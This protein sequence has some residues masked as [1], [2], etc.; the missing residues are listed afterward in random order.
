MKFILLFIFVRALTRGLVRKVEVKGFDRSSEHHA[1]RRTIEGA[2]ERTV[3]RMDSASVEFS[4]SCE[5]SKV[6]GS[7]R[8]CTA[9]ARRSGRVHTPRS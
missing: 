5:A 9:R 2:P 3:Q 7:F 6:R 4:D 8:L 1:P